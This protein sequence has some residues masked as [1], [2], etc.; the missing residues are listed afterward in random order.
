[1]WVSHTGGGGWSHESYCEIIL[2]W[3]YF[4]VSFYPLFAPA[5][6]L[7]RSFS[8]NLFLA[9]LYT[10]VCIEFLVGKISINH[11]WVV[12]E[13]WYNNRQHHSY[14]VTLICK[15]LHHNQSPFPSPDQ[16]RFVSKFNILCILLIPGL[17]STLSITA[18]AIF[19]HL[20][21][22][23]PIKTVSAAKLRKGSTKHYMFFFKKNDNFLIDRCPPVMSYTHTFAIFDNGKIVHL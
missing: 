12:A 22:Y 6:F 13:N 9:F 5:I 11:S 19:N 16:P 14:S 2:R 20:F 21:T 17:L 10:S 23:L 8:G 4:Q 18:K 3:F 15:G 1:M 7:R